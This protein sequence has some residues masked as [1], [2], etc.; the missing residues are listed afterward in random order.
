MNMQF[1]TSFSDHISA[2]IFTTMLESS[3]IEVF[4][5]SDDARGNEIGLTIANGVQ[6]FVP[7]E[8]WEDAKF[9]LNEFLNH[10]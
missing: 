3:G 8:Q 6:I 7:A 1:L 10:K 5:R 9:L 2:D 4:K